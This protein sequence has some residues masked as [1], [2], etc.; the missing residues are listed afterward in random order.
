[1]KLV[2]LNS[3]LEVMEVF[4][5]TKLSKSNRAFLSLL[6]LRLSLCRLQIQFKYCKS[7]FIAVNSQGMLNKRSKP[8]DSRKLTDWAGAFYASN[9]VIGV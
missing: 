3:L 7:C 5:F 2:N 1:M 9:F 4:L 8:K 6:I